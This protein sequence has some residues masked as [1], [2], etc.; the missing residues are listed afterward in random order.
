MASVLARAVD[1]CWL[2][3]RWGDICMVLVVEKEKPAK[4]ILRIAVKHFNGVM[5][6]SGAN[7]VHVQVNGGLERKKHRICCIYRQFL[8]NGWMPGLAC[9]FVWDLALRIERGRGDF[10]S[11]GRSWVDFDGLT[12]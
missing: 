3:I 5:R 12:G 6:V 10:G 4:G 7:L 1:I 2:S 8:I 11:T 9:Y